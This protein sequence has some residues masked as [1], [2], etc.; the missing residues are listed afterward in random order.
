MLKKIINLSMSQKEPSPQGIGCVSSLSVNC[1]SGMALNG[2]R[3]RQT[4][5]ELKLPMRLAMLFR[6]EPTV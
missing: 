4:E 1:Y 3:L 2:A 6:I 5:N